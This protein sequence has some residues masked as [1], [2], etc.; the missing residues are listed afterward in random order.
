MAVEQR[1]THPRK[2]TP[3]SIEEAVSNSRGLPSQ[4]KRRASR[5]DETLVGEDL[6]T[7]IIGDTGGVVR[8]R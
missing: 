3:V 1:S 4:G 5:H 8:G 7:F 2:G 6:M